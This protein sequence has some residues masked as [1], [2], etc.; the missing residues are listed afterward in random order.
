M[1]IKV[2]SRG[3]KKYYGERIPTAQVV[4]ISDGKSET[5]H[6]VCYRNVWM[7]LLG[8]KYDL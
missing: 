1:K 2:I 3:T 8:R 6:L 4:R 7:D 5:R